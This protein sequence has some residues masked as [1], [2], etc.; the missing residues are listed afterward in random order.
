MKI[1]TKYADDAVIEAQIERAWE[2][3]EHYRT[4]NDPIS[5]AWFE[6]WVWRAEF[7]LE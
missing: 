5:A 4:L 7:E 3:A 6:D 2:I 1:P